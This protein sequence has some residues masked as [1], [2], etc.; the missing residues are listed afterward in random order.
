LTASHVIAG[1]SASSEHHKAEHYHKNVVELFFGSTYE[2]GKHGS[3]NGFTVGL[4]YERRISAL[5]GMGGFYEYVS[6]DFDKWSIGIPL[7]LHP[8][9]GWRF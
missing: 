8:Y 7:F 4:V 9:K 5:L 1:E 3:E 6:G 2:D